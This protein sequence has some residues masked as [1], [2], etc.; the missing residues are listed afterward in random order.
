MEMEQRVGRVHRY[1]GLKTI[2]VETLVLKDSRE[3]RVLDRARARLGRIVG[4]LDRDRQ[5]MLF[6]RTMSAI[7]TEASVYGRRELRSSHAR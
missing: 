5:E 4:D 3:R 7:P 1:G 2:I 6:G